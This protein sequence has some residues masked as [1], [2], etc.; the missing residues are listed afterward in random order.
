[1]IYRHFNL[2]ELVPRD[3]IQ[4]MVSIC[5][6]VASMSIYNEYYWERNS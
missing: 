1:M 2:R 3:P 4:I 5:H 6:L